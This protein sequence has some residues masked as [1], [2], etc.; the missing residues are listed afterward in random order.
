M[1]TPSTE[2]LTELGAE[3]PAEKPAD[4]PVEQP[5]DTATG[6]ASDTAT[7]T[8]SAEPPTWGRVDEDGAVFVRTSDGERQVGQWPGGEPGEVLA[9][10]T[11]KYDELV[12]EVDLLEQRLRSGALSPED[13]RGSVKKVRAA[14]AEA[15]AVGDLEALEARL[16]GLDGLIA[17][18]RDKRRA[19]R[20]QRL[21]VTQAD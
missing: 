7:G 15:H 11:R 10:F 14:V 3:P 16:S 20:A 13:A 1:N 8:A 5:S 17:E 19:E 12:F 2:P 9:H 6:T 4:Q 21:V 18:Q